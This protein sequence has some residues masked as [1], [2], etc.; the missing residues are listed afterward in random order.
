MGGFGGIGGSSAK[1]DRATQLAAQQGQWGIFNQGMGMGQAGETTANQTLATAGKM[2]TQPAQYFQN[3]LT[4]GRTQ[5]AQQAA[6]AIAAVTAQ[7]DAARRQEAAF[8][9]DRSGG[10]QAANREAGTAAQS[11]IDQIINQTQQ[12]GRQAGAQGLTQ[13]A[14]LETELGSDQMRN[15]LS[16]LGLSEDAINAILSNA[17]TSRQISNQM[18]LQA[19]EQWGQLA[20]MM[21]M[22]GFGGA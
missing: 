13:V 9:T 18:N 4:G 10:T 1:T 7:E 21:L 14:G 16:Q 6:P 5:T 2:L 11:Q 22:M 12:Q 20:G 19:Q 15:A 8:G 17:T 3:L